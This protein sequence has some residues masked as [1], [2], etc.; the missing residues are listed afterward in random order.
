MSS[1]FADVASRSHLTGPRSLLAVYALSSGAML[2]DAAFSPPEPA[3]ARARFHTQFE[4]LPPVSLLDLL[5]G[6]I[7][8]SGSI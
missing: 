6:A 3:A 5:A 1:L 7:G 8:L 4:A 2:A